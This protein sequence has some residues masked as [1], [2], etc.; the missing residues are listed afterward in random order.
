MT[1]IQQ[2]LFS[3]FTDYASHVA[4][5][6]EAPATCDQCWQLSVYASKQDAAHVSAIK[7]TSIYLTFD[8]AE[9]MLHRYFDRDHGKVD[10][11]SN[12]LKIL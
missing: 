7:G 8:K 9:Q 5:T 6:L 3:V 10:A 1:N 4:R 11:Y 2:E 12:V